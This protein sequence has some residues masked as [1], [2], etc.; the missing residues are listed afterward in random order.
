MSVCS[1]KRWSFEHL[2]LQSCEGHQAL[3]R[4]G[5]MNSRFFINKL[6]KLGKRPAQYNTEAVNTYC[7]KKSE[8]W[9]EHNRIA[10][11][12]LVI[13]QHLCG[14]WK[15]VTLLLM[16]SDFLYKCSNEHLFWYWFAYKPKI[17]HFYSS[18]MVMW[19]WTQDWKLEGIWTVESN[20][21]FWLQRVRT[22]KNIQQCNKELDFHST[23]VEG[24][25]HISLYF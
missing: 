16:Y 19:D 18:C 22:L 25:K 9:R 8:L 17:K 2:Y 7:Y 13:S 10:I 21:H 24:K 5:V 3:Q 11:K 6:E 4:V 23:Y 1:T 15:H 12:E 14:R 20:E